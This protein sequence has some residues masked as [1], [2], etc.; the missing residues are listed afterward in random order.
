MNRSM[1]TLILEDFDWFWVTQVLTPDPY[2][3]RLLSRHHLAVLC[4]GFA[5]CRTFRLWCTRAA[6]K[7]WASFQLRGFH[8]ET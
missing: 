2:R 3:E 5:E 7:H 6:G 8:D 4:G 1:T